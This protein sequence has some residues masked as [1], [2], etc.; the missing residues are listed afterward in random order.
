MTKVNRGEKTALVN[1]YLGEYAKVRFRRDVLFTFDDLL[2]EH[3]I[4]LTLFTN[5]LLIEILIVVQLVKEFQGNSL[6]YFQQP[7]TGLYP[8]PKDSSL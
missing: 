4:T 8:Q 7:T 3:K 6:L 1:I 2:G 5:T